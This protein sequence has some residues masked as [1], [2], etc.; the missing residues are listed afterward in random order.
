MECFFGPITASSRIHVRRVQRQRNL[1]ETFYEMA[2]VSR[3]RRSIIDCR[4]I[5]H[6]RVRCSQWK[7]RKGNY[8]LYVPSDKK[9]GTVR[10]IRSHPERTGACHVTNPVK[11]RIAVGTALWFGCGYMSV[12]GWAGYFC[13][14]YCGTVETPQSAVMSGLPFILVGPLGLPATILTNDEGMM[15]DWPRYVSINLHQFQ[16]ERGGK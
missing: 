8:L 2:T 12:A 1:W 11:V 16:R 3:F 14:R 6:S 13:S 10:S 4:Y 5:A 15:W 9:W 7:Q